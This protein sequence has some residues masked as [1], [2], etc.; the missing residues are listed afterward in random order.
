MAILYR[1]IYVTHIAVWSYVLYPVLSVLGYDTGMGYPT[2]TSLIPYFAFFVTPLL[3]P[4]VS[5]SLAARSLATIFL[6]A[7]LLL[8]EN[9]ILIAIVSALR[10][11]PSGRD[12]TL[13]G[14]GVLL[15]T[16]SAASFYILIANKLAQWNL[17][18]KWLT[19]IRSAVLKGKANHPQDSVSR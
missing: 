5:T 18:C 15:M 17:M 16:L 12:F 10:Y 19:S 7:P 14:S 2:G 9:A 8:A 1:T 11:G 13:L 6:A 4:L 3:P